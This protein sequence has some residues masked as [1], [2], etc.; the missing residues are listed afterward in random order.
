MPLPLARFRTALVV[1]TSR[2]WIYERVFVIVGY[3]A[4]DETL[5]SSLITKP[6]EYGFIRAF[7]LS[8]HFICTLTIYPQ[9]IVKIRD[10]IHRQISNFF[11]WLEIL[12]GLSFPKNG[13]WFDIYIYICTHPLAFMCIKVS[14][15][16]T[17]V[18]CQV[19]LFLYM[20]VCVYTYKYIYIYIY[21]YIYI[22]TC[23]NVYIY[24]YLYVFSTASWRVKVLGWMTTVMRRVPLFLPLHSANLSII[25][26][27][28]CMNIWLLLVGSFNYRSLLQKSPMKETC[29]FQNVECLFSCRCTAQS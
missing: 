5:S 6:T 1:H 7:H 17:T 2:Q 20:Y 9:K 3:S 24:I 23:T 26:S 8:T 25:R 10:Y 12:I 28:I 27:C 21:K 4:T 16:I 22:Y 13:F 15:W 18:T 19:T 14:D 11:A 29:L